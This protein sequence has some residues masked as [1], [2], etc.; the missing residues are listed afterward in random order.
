M[1]TAKAANVVKS[2]GSNSLVL[3]LFKNWKLFKVRPNAEPL[4][5]P[6]TYTAMNAQFPWKYTFKNAWM[7]RYLIYAN[8]MLAP[9]WLWIDTKGMHFDSL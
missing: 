2:V 9:L 4:I 1:A 6:Y 3:A 5:Y 8:I 7:F